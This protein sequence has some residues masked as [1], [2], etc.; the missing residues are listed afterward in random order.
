MRIPE[1]EGI[2]KIIFSDVP[3]SD[4]NGE[5][6]VYAGRTDVLTI[7]D[8]NVYGGKPCFYADAG[9]TAVYEQK[10]R[11]GYWAEVYTI[12][13]A[14]KY[15]KTEV[16]D[17]QKNTS[18]ADSD[19]LYVDSTFYD[20][21]TDYEL[22]GNNRDS[23][24]GDHKVSD[25]YW[26]TFRQFDQALSDYYKEN[27]VSIPIYTGHFQPS[28]W[29]CPFSFINNTLNLYGS[30]NN[31][32]F[33]STNNSS[34]DATSDEKKDKYAC[35]AQGLVSSTL[36]NGVLKTAGGECAEPHFD[37]AFLLGKNSKN[38]VLG[39]V[40]H[41]VSF[42]FKKK[43]DTHGVDYWWFDSSQTTLAMQKDLST[44]K[45]YL[46]NTGAKNWAKNVRSDGSETGTNGFF[47]F[48]ET[49]GG[50]NAAKYNFGF[51]TKLEIKFRLTE[52]GMVLGNDAN[53]VPIIFAFSGDDDV[54]VFI[55]GKLAL[56][57]GGAHGKVTGTLDF[58]GKQ[59]EKKAT[60]SSVKASAAGGDAGK[61]GTD[62]TRDKGTD[63]EAGNRKN[64]RHQYAGCQGRA[65]GRP[66]CH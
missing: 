37:E 38:A 65:R 8:T 13:D 6:K 10:Y 58:S 45:Y 15:K 7:P 23:Y 26:V 50:T 49:V 60:V 12:R 40:Y 35:A 43:K 52:D 2:D 36:T 62:A 42:P 44:P 20:Y 63:G 31:L 18:S 24:P 11:D 46:K 66:D 51:G 32:E 1:E 21:Y 53:D 47:P 5:E 55:D 17:I 14:E 29:N 59:A 34:I 54:W 4:S 9:D 56:D 64:N 22:N 39:E 48:N 41:N 16:V 61:E 27:K 57:V 30:D 25:R 28:F 3:L 19:T 33:F